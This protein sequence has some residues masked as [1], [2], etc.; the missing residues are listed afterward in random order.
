MDVRGLLEG[1]VA[2]ITG[3]SRGIGAAAA[4]LFARAGATVVL[5]A[6]SEDSLT[7]VADRISSDGG[8]ATAVP[9]DVTDSGSVER[10]VARTIEDHGRLDAAFNNAGEG[11]LQG[12]LADIDTPDFDRVLEANLRGTF[13]CLRR[14]IAAML[15]SGGGSIVN[16]ASTAGVGG[17]RGLGAYV[18]AKH[19]IVGLTRSAALDYAAQ[20]VRINAVA[21][22]PIMNDRIASLTDEQRAPIAEAVPMRRIGRPEE[23]AATVAWLC[24]DAASFVTGVVVP[25]D[26]GQLAEI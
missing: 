14:E 7:D 15:E 16:M 5:A 12:P 10:L 20:G 8:S 4:H 19:G 9:T 6:R 25:V 13:L 1:K 17:W 24:S 18:A 11:A 22:G 3:A 2:I 21:P 26:G 23:V